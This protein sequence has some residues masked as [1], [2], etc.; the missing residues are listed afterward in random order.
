MS[1]MVGQAPS[2]Q[3]RDHSACDQHGLHER[4]MG[5]AECNLRLHLSLMTAKWVYT[6]T[7]MQGM[8]AG[9]NHSFQDKFP[10]PA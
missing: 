1:G 3:R 6:F 9:G 5:N 2:D 4:Q 7:L 8:A 10:D